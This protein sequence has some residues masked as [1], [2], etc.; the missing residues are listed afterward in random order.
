MRLTKSVAVLSLGLVA[1]IGGDLFLQ[2][3]MHAVP[4][5]AAEAVPQ[6]TL[7][8]FFVVDARTPEQVA[9]D[10]LEQDARLGPYAAWRQREA[11]YRE[12]VARELSFRNP[13]RIASSASA[14]R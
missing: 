1:A 8:D 6:A 14:G 3:R 2:G 10:A 5:R 13:D 4:P 7:P 11:D 12:A 9:A